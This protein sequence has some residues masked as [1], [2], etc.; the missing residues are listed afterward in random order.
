MTGTDVRAGS[1]G[2]LLNQQTLIKKIID[3]FS[4]IINICLVLV[5]GILMQNVFPALGTLDI[6]GG[7]SSNYI[8]KT[9]FCQVC[10]FISC[11]WM[12]CVCAKG[13]LLLRLK[14]SLADAKLLNPILEIFIL[15]YIVFLRNTGIG[16]GLDLSFYNNF[17]YRFVRKIKCGSTYIVMFW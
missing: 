11:F 3:K 14:N 13:N 5:V 8:Y 10:P 9:F 15:F 1:C 7:L 6:L 12:G 4:D 17:L 16:N 2:Y